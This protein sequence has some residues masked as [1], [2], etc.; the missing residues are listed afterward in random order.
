MPNKSNQCISDRFKTDDER[1]LLVKTD[2]ST[3]DSLSVDLIALTGV[4][5]GRKTIGS[6]GTSEELSVST[7][8]RSVTIKALSTNTGN[9]YVGGS[10]VSSANGFPLEAKG[11][12]SLDIDDLNDVF[13]DVDNNGEGVSFIFLT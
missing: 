8:I 1:F 5:N 10:A 6:S 3:G 4:G 2:S 7:I 12:V 13:I 11:S 9:V